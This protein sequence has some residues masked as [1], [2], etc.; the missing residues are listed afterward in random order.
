MERRNKTQNK[1]DSTKMHETKTNWPSITGV[2]K[3]ELTKMHL[4]PVVKLQLHLA[5]SRDYGK[6]ANSLIGADD[7]APKRPSVQSLRQTIEI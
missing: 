2:P 1:N 4:F 5:L 7:L 6:Q 3:M